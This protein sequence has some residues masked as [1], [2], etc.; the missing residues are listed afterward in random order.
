[1]GEDFY[2]VR[3]L[4]R[5]LLADTHSFVQ[6]I[7]AMVSSHS[8]LQGATRSLNKWKADLP[9]SPWGELPVSGA[10]PLINARGLAAALADLSSQEALGS[11]RRGSIS[12]PHC[13]QT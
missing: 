7:M 4:D 6:A 1:M 13:K 9:G 12:A 3:P 8:G 2:P 11:C 5:L 10:N